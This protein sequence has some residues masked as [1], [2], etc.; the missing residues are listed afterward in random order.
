LGSSVALMVPE[1]LSYESGIDAIGRK[2][3]IRP[4]SPNK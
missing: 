4:H 1:L 2:K 3:P